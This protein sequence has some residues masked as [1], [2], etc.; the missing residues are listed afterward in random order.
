MP[1]LTPNERALPWLTIIEN[2]KKQKSYKPI[3]LLSII[4]EIEKGN[5]SENKIFFSNDLEE[6]FDS[7][8]SD[9]HNDQGI[10]KLYLPFYFLSSDAWS[11][12]TKSPNVFIKERNKG[13]L[14]NKLSYAKFNGNLFDLLLDPTVRSIIKERLFLKAEEDI[15][16]K[17]ILDNESSIVLNNIHTVLEENFGSFNRI[18]YEFISDFSLVDSYSN[19]FKFAFEKDLQNTLV[20]NWDLIP[21]FK[22]W[23]IYEGP[24]IGNE[25][26]VNE[27][28]R[29]D[30]LAQGKTSSEL[31]VIELKRN[32]G[33]SD[34][35][36]QLLR[37]TGW[38]RPNFSE[39][40]NVHG[41]LI[42]Q[43]LNQGVIHALRE[44]NLQ[45]IE[46]LKFNLNVQIG[47]F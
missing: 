5:I 16:K 15:K 13:D 40:E 6:L 21:K 43:D 30:I 7:F 14:V 45:N 2:M 38:V 17:D 4:S 23:K 35:L 25:Y 12:V 44:L 32:Q 19:A 46:L 24:P 28:G 42:A 10:G 18:E 33:V 11:F 31:I 22:D 37:Y 26:K 9:L 27:A 47:S 8:Y 39:I 1:N 29:I 3:L 20:H 41:V 34:N 36:G